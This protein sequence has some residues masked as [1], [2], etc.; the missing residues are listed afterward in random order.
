VSVLD[1]PYFHRPRGKKNPRTFEVTVEYEQDRLDFERAASRLG[2]IEMANFFVFA[3]RVTVW[4]I[5]EVAF[6]DQPVEEVKP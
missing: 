5:T 3:A 2:Q 6:R 4:L 1:S